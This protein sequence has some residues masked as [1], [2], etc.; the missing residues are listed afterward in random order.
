MKI[1]HLAQNEI[2]QISKRTKASLAVAKERGVILGNPNAAT[3]LKTA[4]KAIQKRKQEFA[5]KIFATIQEIRNSG[6]KS[7]QQIAYHLNE[8][9]EK[10]RRHGFWTATAVK[11]VLATVAHV[12]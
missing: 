4:H 7:L 11:R 8:R 5:V 3:A 9:G 2:Q 10:T 12:F 1:A 6:I